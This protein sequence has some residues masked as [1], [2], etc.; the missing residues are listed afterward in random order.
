MDATQIHLTETPPV[1]CASCY[2]QYTDRAHVDFG[3]TYDG[4][5][6]NQVD[7]IST[8]VTNVQIDELIIC[9]HCL[10]AAA[11]LIGLVDPGETTE[12]LKEMAG[13]IETLSERLAGAMALLDAKE[14]SEAKRKSLLIE[15]KG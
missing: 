11:A 14:K 5:V 12:Q 3:A 6:L 9:D 4:P 7:V 1:A 2:G 13:R 15:M 10:N 8:G